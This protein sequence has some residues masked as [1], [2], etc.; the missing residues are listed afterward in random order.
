MYPT[1]AGTHGFLSIQIAVLLHVGL[2]LGGTVLLWWL[3]LPARLAVPAFVV[4]VFLLLVPFWPV[5][6]D[7][8][9]TSGER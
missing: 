4:A 8:H 7:F 6:A 2:A 9:P 5:Y 3:G 1:D